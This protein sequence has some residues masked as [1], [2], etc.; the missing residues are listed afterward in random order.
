MCFHECAS[1]SR[2]HAHFKNARFFNM[3]LPHFWTVFST[4]CGTLK[5]SSEPRVP[6]QGF[7]EVT[8]GPQGTLKDQ[9]GEERGEWRHFGKARVVYVCGAVRVCGGCNAVSNDVLMTFLSCV[10][11]RYDAVCH[12]CATR[13]TASVI[14]LMLICHLAKSSCAVRTISH[15]KCL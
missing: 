1:Y 7:V 15:T 3:G 2:K 4:I 9:G 8:N 12:L 10:F 6:F 13:E 5:K 14:C 11:D